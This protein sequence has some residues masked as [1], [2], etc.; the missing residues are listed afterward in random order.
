MSVRVNDIL[1]QGIWTQGD[2]Q[3]QALVTLKET[4]E[5]SALEFHPDFSHI[6][7]Q[8]SQTGIRLSLAQ[9][10]DPWFQLLD[11]CNLGQPGYVYANAPAP[12]V[13]WAMKGSRQY[14]TLVRWEERV[15]EAVIKE[16]GKAA[17][18]ALDN[19][20]SSITQS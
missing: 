9:R 16:L 11:G 17:L 14:G 6:F 2:Y 5:G 7:R 12:F 10:E 18:E 15:A 19:P 1:A 3:D 8:I 13:Y 4:E 20:F